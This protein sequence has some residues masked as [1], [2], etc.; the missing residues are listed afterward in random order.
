MNSS[1]VS[2]AAAKAGDSPVI[3]WGARLGYVTVGLHVDP[4]LTAMV[5]A[6]SPLPCS[7]HADIGIVAQ[8]S[9]ALVCHL[10]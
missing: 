5:R 3:E 10:D 1:D 9:R 6:A 4:S 8:S 7:L 2:A